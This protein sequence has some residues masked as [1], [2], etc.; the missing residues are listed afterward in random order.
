MVKNMK[1]FYTLWAPIYDK[2]VEKPTTGLRRQSLGR[3]GSK[4]DGRFVLLVGVGTGLDFPHLPPGGNY[5]GVDL[6]PAMLQKARERAEGMGL[7]IDLREGDALDLPFADE[8]FD[9]VV[10]HMILAVVKSPDK[11]LEEACRVLK[12]GGRVIIADKFLRPGE[13][14]P[15]RR[16]LGIVLGPIA[17]RTDV[18]FEYLIRKQPEFKVLQDSPALLRGWFRSIELEKI[19]RAQAVPPSKAGQSASEADAAMDDE[20][21]STDTSDLRSGHGKGTTGGRPS[22]RPG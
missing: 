16:L 12:P 7:D 13:S 10:L 6:T 2:L 11:A 9:V 21:A 19:P 14:A 18:V 20:D 8:Q 17:T 15:L 5:F 1:I 4:A 22:A 3:L